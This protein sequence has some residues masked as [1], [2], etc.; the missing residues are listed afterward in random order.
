MGAFS[1]QRTF[2]VVLATLGASRKCV[3]VHGSKHSYLT[4]FELVV[5][6]QNLR[7]CHERRGSGK[8]KSRPRS[9]NTLA[10][11]RQAQRHYR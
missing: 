3:E 9:A 2:A 4:N 11:E 8:N 7:H 10:R 1:G 6:L 5:T